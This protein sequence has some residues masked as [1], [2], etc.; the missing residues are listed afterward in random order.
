MWISGIF[1]LILSALGSLLALAGRL[2]GFSSPLFPG[3]ALLAALAG[4]LILALARRSCQRGLEALGEYARAVRADP[5]GACP[6]AGQDALTRPLA[7]DLQ[8][9]RARV[10]ELGEQV[11][12]EQARVLERE[13]SLK[14][15]A[16]AA[17][18]QQQRF[19]V[20]ESQSRDTAGRAG[21]SFETLAGDMRNLSRM[22]AE[23]GNGA[24]IQ[25]FRLN[26]TAEAMDQIAGSVREVTTSVR[27]AS[28]QA[29][30]SRAKAKSGARELRDAVDD[31]EN[32]KGVTLDLCEAMGE[33]EEKTSNIHSVMG[34]ISEVADQTNLLALNAA[35]EAARAGEAGRGFAVVAD[36]VRKLAEK[37]MLATGE[38]HKV[39][40]G[41]QENASRNKQHVSAAAEAIVRSAERAF[42]AGE[43]MDQIVAEL[44]ASAVQFASIAKAAEEQLAGSARTNEALESISA[45]AADTADQMQRFTTQLVRISDNRE[46]LEDIIGAL[47]RGED[48]SAQNLRPMAWTPDLAMGIELIDNQH[49]MLCSYINALHRAVRQKTLESS[50]RDIL[51]NLKKYT[52]SHFSTE[53]HYFSRSGYPDTERHKQIHRKFV[54]KVVSVEKQ[55]LAGQI[56]VGDDLLDFLKDW[57]FTH[58]RVTDHQYGPFVKAFLE[59]ELKRAQAGQETSRKPNRPAA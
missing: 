55:L 38:V 45:V 27:L 33:M 34:V 21:S 32:V 6:P 29:E 51:D 49:K 14:S 20:A 56:Q 5:A 35:I 39:L 16:A 40:G 13:Q 57:L 12:E 9:L 1:F 44:E 43:V 11:R 58:I 36:E 30:G 48:A 19:L 22:V 2:Y 31:I 4:L 3:L 53:E 23:V 42:R 41:I 8:A 47:V 18:E 17:G 50:G 25:R 52:V 24:E 59:T 54:D 26:E 15:N 28:E 46:E 10:L 7:E 37:T